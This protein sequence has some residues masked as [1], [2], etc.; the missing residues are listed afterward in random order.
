MH[1][2][3]LFQLAFCV[4][5]RIYWIS[6]SSSGGSQIESCSGAG[7]DRQQ[8][9]STDLW[10]PSSL[11][12]DPFSQQLLWIDISDGGDFRLERADLDGGNRRLVCHG[13]GQTP[14]DMVMDDT[15]VFWSDWKN[16]IV[17]KMQKDVPEGGQCQISA[18]RRLSRARPMGML[19]LIDV[20]AACSSFMAVTES[21]RL[22]SKA[23]TTMQEATSSP[24]HNYCLR[25]SCLL[26]AANIPVCSCSQGFGGPRC[27]A[28]LCENFCF[29]GTCTVQDNEA[30]CVCPDGI[31]G[32]RCQIAA[33][34]KPT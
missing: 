18:F 12:I 16:M 32:N 26:T 13:K 17:W 29:Q 33:L 11:A 27:Q 14:F 4:I 25:G 3:A 7:D 2:F 9:V 34:T 8:V 1:L 6:W 21:E 10:Q 19:M 23:V 20:E 22:T 30:V 31:S 5:S 28:D 15:A 24:C